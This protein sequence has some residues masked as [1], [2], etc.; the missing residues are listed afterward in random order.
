MIESRQMATRLLRARNSIFPRNEMSMSDDKYIEYIALLWVACNQVNNSALSGEV[1]WEMSKLSWFNYQMNEY[2]ES[3]VV[4][5]SDSDVQWLIRHVSL[6]CDAV[7]KGDGANDTTDMNGM[8]SRGH[9][10]DT[11]SS[12]ENVALVLDHYV[13]YILRHSKVVLSPSYISE[14]LSLE[15]ENFLLAHIRQN[16]SNRAIRAARQPESCKNLVDKDTSESTIEN[17]TQPTDLTQ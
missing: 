13:E 17:R 10:I 14:E 2:M 16:L 5:L 12:L 3:V 9:D 1:F 11:V 8:A 15:A 4:G 6:L 7:C